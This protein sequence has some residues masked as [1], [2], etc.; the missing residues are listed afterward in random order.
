MAKAPIPNTA[1]LIFTTDAKDNYSALIAIP[2]CKEALNLP[3]VITSLEKNDT[4]LLS[5][6]LIIINVNNRLNDQNQD[7]QQTLKWLRSYQGP[8]NLAFLDS[9]IEPYAYPEKFGVG[10][11]RHQAV[12]S[13]LDYISSKAPVI[14]LDG[15]SPVNPN[16]L[17][18]IFSYI[19]NSPKF[20]AGHVNFKHRLEGSP[21]E[22]EAI[23]LYDRHLHL[24]REQL[25]KANSPHAWYAIGSTIICTKEAYL[26]SGGYNPRRMAGE[27][28]YLLQQL[29]KV[30]YQIEMID[31][32][33]VYPSNR[34]SY[35]VPFGTGKAVSDILKSGEWL[36]Y[37][38]QCYKILK[39]VLDIIQ[40]NL[41]KSGDDLINSLPSEG[42]EWFIERKFNEI[43][44]K[45]Q[46][47]S[48]DE[49]ALLQRFHE[50]LDAF[51]TLKFI[52]F[53]SDKYYPKVKIEL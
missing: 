53:L 15:D 1:S 40:L 45:L 32:A 14:S 44:A 50:W 26:K 34:E 6:T 3:D 38:P 24:H 21:E 39:S 23:Q 28:F 48:K 11:A 4:S 41:H 47:N 49:N 2:S 18:E 36:T 30:G 22:I 35:R 31:K 17:S 42:Q 37:H 16:Y 13:G 10:L 52:H 43:W 9:T 27:D 51:Q 20:G 29:S 7:N 12:T 5:E 33:F 46:A 8:A 25:E 19:N